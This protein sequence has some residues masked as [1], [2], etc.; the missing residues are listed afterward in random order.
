M[1][2]ILN[3]AFY[4]KRSLSKIMNKIKLNRYYNTIESYERNATPLRVMSLD[5]IQ[6]AFITKVDCKYWNHW[7]IVM[8]LKEDYYNENENE[9]RPNEDIN[10]YF[11]KSMPKSSILIINNNLTFY[12]GE[13]FFIPSLF[14]LSYS[15][16]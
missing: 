4:P 13:L 5:Q 15:F 3:T 6:K 12:T 1:Y 2:V 7:F 11:I 8:K 10:S 14:I 9:K 16:R